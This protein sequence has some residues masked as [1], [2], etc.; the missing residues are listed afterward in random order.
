MWKCKNCYQE[1]EDAVNRC[2][3]CGMDRERPDVSESFTP[4]NDNPEPEPELNALIC[5]NCGVQS[6]G[7]SKS[8]IGCGSDF[9]ELPDRE[10]PNEDKSST[11]GERWI[12]NKCHQ[13]I[14]NTYNTC[15]R[16]GTDREGGGSSESFTSG[17]DNPEPEPKTLICRKCGA[18]NNS[19]LKSCIDCGSRLEELAHREFHDKDKSSTPDGI[20]ICSKCQAEV[21]NS[22]NICWNCGTGREGS[23]P[24]ESFASGLA[25]LE[26]PE[27]FG[28]LTSGHSNRQ[29]GGNERPKVYCPECGVQ[30]NNASRY[31]NNCGSSLEEVPTQDIDYEYK[32]YSE[33][34]SRAREGSPEQVIGIIII[35]ILFL[36]IKGCGN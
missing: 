17:R 16:C 9:E 32:G 12:C 26:E 20:W 7:A 15:W 33:G 27:S 29:P 36:I 10:L 8:C 34:W 11:R 21:E 5:P 14:D 22:F 31:C 25:D 2:F 18:L 24:P 35:F 28:P 19:V 13:D 1:I 30:G 3:V 6:N 4:G 23:E